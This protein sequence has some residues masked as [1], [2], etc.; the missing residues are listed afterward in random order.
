VERVLG[1]GGM[2]VVVAAYHEQLH[3]QVAIKFL[4][5]GAASN[6]LAVA[7]FLNEARKAV[8]VKSEYV[9]RVLDV[10]SLPSGAPYMVLEFLN[11]V[12]LGLLLK[13][14]GKLGVE[15][16]VDFVLQAC[17]AI[18]HAHSIG[19][20][21]RDLKPAN[22]FC[23]QRP[24]RQR[25]IKV[26]DFGISKATELSDTGQGVTR[27]GAIMGSPLYM[28]PEQ[29]RSSKDV[30]ARADIWS[31]GVVLFELLTARP[32]FTG[33]T[34]PELVMKVSADE[35]PPLRSLLPDAPIGLEALIVRCLRKDRD[36]RYPNVAELASALLPFG[37]R[38]ASAWVEEIRALTAPLDAEGSSPPPAAGTQSNPRVL[39]LTLKPATLATP[40]HTRSAKKSIAGSFAVLGALLAALW[41]LRHPIARV[42]SFGSAAHELQPLDASPVP[43]AA[44][45]RAEPPFPAPPPPLSAAPTADTP[46]SANVPP[47]NAPPASALQ[48]MR[49]PGSASAT[50]DKRQSSMKRTAV[51][52]KAPPPSNQAPTPA[53]APPNC[54]P[55][56]T[57]DAAGHRQYKPECP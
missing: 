6:E 36:Q 44:S 50:V 19:I 12:D 38:R 25:A 54:N 43:P 2:G 47:S 53:A 11:G 33:S 9:A 35:A 45:S 4:L 37:S 14:E 24:D 1:A 48:G 42:L 18:A 20:V 10:G 51:P 41:L 3:E 34:L 21:H 40:V 26:L 29:M 23:V 46:S 49:A 28:S 55:P 5:P 27:T 15:R 39:T 52:T 22:L 56:Y 13:S 57:I 17:V 16:A 31:L 30:D 7:Q 32:P 8:R